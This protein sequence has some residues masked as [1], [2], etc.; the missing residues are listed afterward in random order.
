[1]IKYNLLPQNSKYGNKTNRKRSQ[2]KGIN[3]WQ[4]KHKVKCQKM[5]CMVAYSTSCKQ[6]LSLLFSLSLSLLG[7]LVKTLKGHSTHLH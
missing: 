4:S 7:A 2:Q 5:C 3:N 1:M 6:L